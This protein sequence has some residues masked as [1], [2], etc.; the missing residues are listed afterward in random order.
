MLFRSFALDDFG[1]GFS[2][3]YYLKRFEVDYLKIDGG[4]IRDLGSDNSN[5]VFVKA[6]ND[7][8]RGMG[9]QV[10][11]QWVETPEI[12]TLLQ[13]IGAQYGQ[14]YLFSAPAMLEGRPGES[15]E[16]WSAA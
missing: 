13:E 1:A 12:L 8:A 10:I 7:V 4:F 15:A 9:R 5:Q 16:N 6:L 14:G 3:F 11:A 2:S